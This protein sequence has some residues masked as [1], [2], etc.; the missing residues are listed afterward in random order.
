M[1]IILLVEYITFFN[2]KCSV[3]LLR[4]FCNI[5]IA[6]E[7]CKICHDTRFDVLAAVFKQSRLLK[8]YATRSGKELKNF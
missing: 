4:S 8:C 6:E 3:C 2:L 5:G 7:L 1:L